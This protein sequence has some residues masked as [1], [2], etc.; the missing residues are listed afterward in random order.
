MD[1]KDAH[2]AQ[3]SLD[4]AF[5][6]SNI[7]DT[8]LDRHTLSVLI[9]LCDIGLNPEALATVVKEL[10]REGPS[11]HRMLKIQLSI[12]GHSLR[13]LISIGSKGVACVF[14]IAKHNFEHT[15]VSSQISKHVVSVDELQP[16]TLSHVH[17]PPKNHKNKSKWLKFF[18]HSSLDALI[19][20]MVPK[21]IQIG[22]MKLS[23]LNEE[24]TDSQMIEHERD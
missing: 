24:L 1:P 9:A 15:W 20:A 4:L 21:S 22:L 17:I 5:H 13:F 18:G 3:E 19:D 14:D 2:M 23:K 6:M 11:S 10:R 7:L 12:S 8:R 16:V